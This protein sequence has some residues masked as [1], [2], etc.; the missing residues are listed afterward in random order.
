[1]HE[2][3]EICT[4]LLPDV[5]VSDPGSESVETVVAG[6]SSSSSLLNIDEDNEVEGS[7]SESSLKRKRSGSDIVDQEGSYPTTLGVFLFLSLK[8]CLF[9]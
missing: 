5:V 1:M 3:D 2:S 8:C 6:P 9:F 4:K 7:F